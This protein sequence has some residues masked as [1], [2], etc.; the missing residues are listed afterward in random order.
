M[1]AEATGKSK[2]PEEVGTDR[3]T[4]LLS[5]LRSIVRRRNEAAH[6]TRVKLDAAEELYRGLNNLTRSKLF[7][8]MHRLK[9]LYRGT[10]SI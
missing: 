1:A 10:S 9:C 5:E 6:E 8:E 2:R 7:N 4:F 3:W